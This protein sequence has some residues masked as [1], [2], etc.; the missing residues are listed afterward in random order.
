LSKQISTKQAGNAGENYV[1]DLLKANGWQIIATQWH[2]RWGEL[3][4]VARDRTWLIF[5]EVKTRGCKSW[6]ESGL[7]AISSQKQRKIC[8]AASEFLIYRPDLAALDCRF[9]IALVQRVETH[10][11]QIL[12][13][14][15]NYIEAGFSVE[16]M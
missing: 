3:D 7:L 12:L 4:I 13:E 10:T 15:Q 1:A 14:L 5:V 16:N 9:D 8:R 2:C 11:K 6:D